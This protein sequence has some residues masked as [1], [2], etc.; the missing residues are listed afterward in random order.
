MRYLVDENMLRKE[1]YYSDDAV[2]FG[3]EYQG[4]WVRWR[5]IEEALEKFRV[6]KAVDLTDWKDSE[7]IRVDIKTL[8]EN[9]KSHLDNYLTEV[10]DRIVEEENKS[11]L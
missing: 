4:L 3:G 6:E 2:N 7:E 11:D 8:L 10:Y 1:L 5:A 9:N